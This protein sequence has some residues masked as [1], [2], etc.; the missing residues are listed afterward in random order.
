VAL[1]NE[2]E[3]IEKEAEAE[4]EGLSFE[5]EDLKITILDEDG[6]R[7]PAGHLFYKAGNEF[8]IGE[9]SYAHA[10]VSKNITDRKGNVHRKTYETIVPLLVWSYYKDGE[11][12]ERIL[13]PYQ[14]AR[15]IEVR[16]RPVLIELGTRYAGTL[17]TLISLDMAK[18]FLNGENGEGWKD[19]FL[20]IKLYLEK[21]VSFSW[22]PK[23]YNVVACWILGTYFSELFSTYPF[24]YAYGSQGT[25]KSRLILTATYLSR[26]G[27]IATDPSEASLFRMSEA[28]KP[29]L[30]IDES[31][32]GKSAWK[33]VR[34]AFKKGMKVPRVEKTSR[35]EFLLAL[36]ET[37][38]P[39]AFASTE[40]P[41]ELGGSEADE[42]R[43]LFI[44]M[45]R[46]PDPIGRDPDKWEFKSLR[47]RLFLLRL[48]KANDV[49]SALKRIESS[50][51]PLY[52]H[53]REVWLPLLTI[54]SLIGDEVFSDVMEYAVELGMIKQAFQYQEERILTRAILI[55]YR[56]QYK[57]AL[58]DNPKAYLPAI[59]FKAA[60][61]LEYVKIVLE[62]NGEYEEGTFQ[63]YWTSR[64]IGRLLT[65]IGLFR[66]MRS[67]IN[68][69]VVTAKELQSLY[70]RFWSG[71]LGVLSVLK[72]KGVS[73]EKS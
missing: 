10:V 46:T 39:I 14:L 57:K 69:Y 49:F 63:K 1:S 22:N 18:R 55:A 62:E 25:G 32:L 40:R 8:V 3:K 60:N 65:K 47:D 68:Y 12:T 67:G 19:L 2:I 70:K 11:I 16:E 42:A 71:V 20:E 30:G 17:E 52:G 35:E 64:R 5:N 53:D 58:K 38:M 4:A 45:Q 7:V 36:F 6:V 23:L 9:I 37:Y 56:E 15:K 51:L 44:F 73:K 59:E 21:F 27:F 33:L 54:A 61:L 43:A 72:K 29:T 50:N 24:L 13:K 26:H 31:L 66:R 48:T 34:T 41:S 28:F